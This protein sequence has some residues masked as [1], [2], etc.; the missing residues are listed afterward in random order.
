MV[1]NGF[2]GY[3]RVLDSIDR[4]AVFAGPNDITAGFCATM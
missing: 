1:G 4:T 2:G 3:L